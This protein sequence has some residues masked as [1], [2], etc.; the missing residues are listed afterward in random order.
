MRKEAVD[1][2]RVAGGVATQL[3]RFGVD[4]NIILGQTMDEF[5]F[6]RRRR[7]RLGNG[8][9]DDA[10]KRVEN[11]KKVVERTDGFCDRHVVAGTSPRRKLRIYFAARTRA[12]LNST[13]YRRLIRVSNCDRRNFGA[14]FL[15][16]LARTS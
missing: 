10:E 8:K 9:T 15:Y 16:S 11:N 14:S 4:R 3:A 12:L 1:Y 6:T 7:L 2:V 5:P 13:R